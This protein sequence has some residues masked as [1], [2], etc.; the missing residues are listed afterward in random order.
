M[1]GIG[2]RSLLLVTL[3]PALAFPAAALAQ[4]RRLSPD[5]MQRVVRMADPQLSP[6]GKSVAVVISRANMIDNRWDGQLTLIDVATGAQRVLSR[7]RRGLSSLRWSP[8]GQ[9]LAFLANDAGGRAQVHLMA[10]AGGDARQLTSSK[11]SVTHVSWRPDGAALAYA[12]ADAEP[13]RTGEARFEDGFEVGNNG[14]LERAARQPTHVWTVAVADGAVKRLTSGVRSI[15]I[16]LAPSGPPPQLRWTPDGA[17]ILFAQADTSAGGD[18]SSTRLAMIDVASGAVRPA[19][20]SALPSPARQSQPILS[21]DG[22][23]MAFVTARAGM[24]AHQDRVMIAATSG[25]PARDAAPDLDVA[26]DVVGWL[27]DNKTLLLSGTDGTRS[28]LWAARDGKAARI[29]LGDLDPVQASV[30]GGAVTFTATTADRPPELFT[31]ASI[32]AKPAALTRLQTVTDGAALGRQESISWKSDE[33]TADGV[34]TYPPGYTP[35]TRLP[36]VLYI[37]GGPVAASRQSFSMSPQLLAA[38][39]WLVLEPNYRGS[40]NRGHRFQEAILGDAV[41]GPG[42]DIMAGVALLNQRGLIDP[43]RVAATGWSYG[44]M[45]TSWLIGA[46]PEAWAAAVAGAPVT[47]IVDQYTTADGNRVRAAQYGPSPFV[48]D[49]MASYSRQS[50]IFSAWRA[51]APTLIMA[52]VGDWRVT[53]PQ[54]YKLYRALSDNNVP[55]K[56]IAYPV[57]GHSPADP[58][59]SRDVWRRWVDWLKP[60][61]NTAQPAKP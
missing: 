9:T 53:I 42:R 13:E 38:Q 27:P 14:F 22:R 45:M 33:L 24:A 36:L 56:F 11:T 59:R 49:N 58:I 54:A 8:D 23:V 25:G 18:A 12:A 31:M 57:P 50:P 48:G 26:L 21:P 1:L 39:G 40:N 34:L 32:T 37:H 35:G 61:L 16:G 41:A 44:G 6:D 5:D 28:G 30:Q 19:L 55:V 20:P 2:L 29:N 10:M 17:S 52:D 15:P 4:E 7:D 51:K 60:Y 47:D 3:A 46:Y 43:A